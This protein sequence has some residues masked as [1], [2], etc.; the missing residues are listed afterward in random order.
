[1]A[2]VRVS[3]ASTPIVSLDR[4]FRIANCSISCINLEI[5]P[6]PSYLFWIRKALMFAIFS[7]SHNT[8]LPAIALHAGDNSNVPSPIATSL[9]RIRKV[10]AFPDRLFSI[11]YFFQSIQR[12]SFPFSAMF[13][14]QR[15]SSSDSVAR[16]YNIRNPL[17]SACVFVGLTNLIL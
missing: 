2:S 12:L 9:C 1:M 8:F 15:D 11:N 4:W 7:P 5:W 3:F 6:C 16:W 13:R 17:S 10:A 14:F